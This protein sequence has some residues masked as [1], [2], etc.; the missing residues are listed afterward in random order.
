MYLKILKT[1][2]HWGWWLVTGVRHKA[3]I[4]ADTA[5]KARKIALG[6]EHIGDW[7]SISVEFAWEEPPEIILC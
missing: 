5:L 6:S 3:F 2:R 7:E 4:Y 1:D